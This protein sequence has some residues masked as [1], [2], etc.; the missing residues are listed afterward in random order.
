MKATDD[1]LNDSTKKRGV[2]RRLGGWLLGRAK[3]GTKRVVTGVWDLKKLGILGSQAIR[4]PGF[5]SWVDG[6]FSGGPATS[7]AA[8][9]AQ[10]TD[11]LEGAG[12]GAGGDGGAGAGAGAAA[13]GPPEQENIAQRLREELYKEY[14][15]IKYPT[16]GARFIDE[17]AS[18]KAGKDFGLGSDAATK[19][20]YNKWKEDE[21]GE[22]GFSSQY[23]IN[24]V[25]Q[26]RKEARKYRTEK[27]NSM[28]REDKK[29]YLN[30]RIYGKSQY[31]E[32]MAS[33]G[34]QHTFAGTVGD[35][36]N[37]KRTVLAPDGTRRGIGVA[38]EANSGAMTGAAIAPGGIGAAIGA[39]IGAGISAIKPEMGGS[40]D[41]LI[42]LLD[43][44]PEGF[45]TGG[46]VNGPPGRDV[47][48][49]YLSRGEFVMRSS[50]VNNIGRDNLTKMNAQN[51]YN[52]GDVGKPETSTMNPMKIEGGKELLEA[53]RILKDA[54]KTIPTMINMTVDQLPAVDANIKIDGGQIV[55]TIKSAVE[56]WVGAELDT[57]FRDYELKQQSGGG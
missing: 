50:A 35:A 49:A 36:E 44:K 33:Q 51:F 31:G 48:P 3:A 11:A 22:E 20:L 28:S 42:G 6:L 27:V 1:A 30:A 54:A 47:I 37:E 43:E 29:A 32:G 56:E 39:T 2:L 17:D 24:N 21:I 34:Y 13:A 26:F 55:G 46:Y 5:M 53:G 52:G 7:E 15:A 4:N 9:D 16:I 18:D 12:G 23:L 41:K 8:A 19:W 14:N 10:A 38:M 40:L 25:G 57:R 45:Y